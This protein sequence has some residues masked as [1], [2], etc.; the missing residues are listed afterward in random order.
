MA[1]NIV[2]KISVKDA[3]GLP[4]TYDV[5]TSADKVTYGNDSTVKDKLDSLGTA[6]YKTVGAANGVAPLGADGKVPGNYL[7]TS[8]GKNNVVEAYRNPLD[9]LFY[10]EDTYTTTI[11]GEVDIIYIDLTT[12]NTYR[13]DANATP[14]FVQIGGS[15]REGSVVEGY[16]DAEDTE[17][18]YENY[19]SGTGVFSDLITGAADTIYIDLLADSTYRYDETD[20]EY[21][22]IGGGGGSSDPRIDTAYAHSQLTSGNPHQVTKSDVGLANVE[23]YKSLAVSQVQELSGTEKTN[24]I[25]NLGLAVIKSYTGEID[26]E[27]S[28]KVFYDNIFSEDSIIIGVYTNNG[29][30]YTSI[31]TDEVAH[32][33]TVNYDPE[34][35]TEVFKVTIIVLTDSSINNNVNSDTQRWLSFSQ[36]LEVE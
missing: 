12:N 28:A 30:L 19:N 21:I 3:S 10:E 15:G 14:E 32:T 26:L 8:Q 9:G 6:A 7:P 2:N 4:Q 34:E 1:N 35:V 36:V 18:F 24:G 5:S 11:S 33:I 20:E 22:Q 16:Y 31:E 25:K 27:T 23:N 29:L 17:E 13:W